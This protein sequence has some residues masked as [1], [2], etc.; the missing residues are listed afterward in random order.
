MTDFMD[1]F[2]EP[3]CQISLMFSWQHSLW[4]SSLPRISWLS[5]FD[6]LPS[7]MARDRA[8]LPS[9]NF[10]IAD[11]I[12]GDRWEEIGLLITNDQLTLYRNGRRVAELR[13]GQ[14]IDG[15]AIE[16]PKQL[17]PGDQIWVG[18]ATLDGGMTYAKCPI[19][20]A[21]VYKLGASEF[22][23]LPQGVYPMT[24]PSQTA[25]TAVEYRVLAHPEG[26]VELSS[27]I[28]AD[29]SSAQGAALNTDAALTTGTIFLG[30]DFTRAAGAGAT[31]RGANSAQVSVSIDGRVH[32]SLILVPE[33]KPDSAD[34]PAGTPAT[35]GQ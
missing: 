15:R 10:D 7:D 35:S 27:A 26:R 5:S 20:D 33:K 9:G 8:K 3:F 6:H 28:G 18:Q 14:V 29:T 22:G 13:A 16:L 24:D 23:S 31:T 34:A 11:P 17:I 25:N 19:D 21:R 4:Q 30:G 2:S 12:G 1:F 32:G